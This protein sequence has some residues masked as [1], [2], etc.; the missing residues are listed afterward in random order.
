MSNHTPGK[1]EVRETEPVDTGLD[2]LV[3]VKGRNKPIAWAYALG[4]ARLIAAAPDMLEAL[5]DVYADIFLHE[6]DRRHT[7]IR[8]IIERI[9]DGENG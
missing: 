6:N 4:D 2:K 3:R 9:K 1:W 7:K 5:E 8:K